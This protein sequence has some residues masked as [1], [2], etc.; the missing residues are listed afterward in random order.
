MSLFYIRF[1]HIRA[2]LKTFIQFSVKP[3]RQIS[4][5]LSSTEH[6]FFPN[7]D[8]HPKNLKRMMVRDGMMRGRGLMMK[9]R[10]FMFLLYI[11]QEK[12]IEIWLVGLVGHK[13]VSA[14]SNS[15]HINFLEKLALE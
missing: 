6:D 3:V 8:Y 7:N 9:G 2:G 5:P 13:M 4:S 14:T 15:F 11:Y 1:L 10:G 12:K